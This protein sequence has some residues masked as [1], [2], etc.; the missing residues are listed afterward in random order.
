[1]VTAVV[2]QEKVAVAALIVDH[3]EVALG[4]L[5]A[6]AVLAVVQEMV[7]DLVE[8]RQVSS[9]VSHQVDRPEIAKQI[10]KTA[11]P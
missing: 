2:V 8:D 5:V 1:L 10:T 11:C 7:L 6:V 3:L 4:T 9:P